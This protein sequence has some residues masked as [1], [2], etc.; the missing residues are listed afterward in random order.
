M[1][2][3]AIDPTAGTAD[4]PVVDDRQVRRQTWPRQEPCCPLPSSIGTRKPCTGATASPVRRGGCFPRSR[5]ALVRL[6]MRPLPDGCR[7]PSCLAHGNPTSN[8]RRSRSPM[9]CSARNSSAWRLCDAQLATITKSYCLEAVGGTSK[10]SALTQ[11]AGPRRTGK[12]GT[13]DTRDELMIRVGEALH[14]HRLPGYCEHQQRRIA[15]TRPARFENKLVAIHQ[16]AQVEHRDHGTERPDVLQQDDAFLSDRSR[17]QHDQIAQQVGRSVS[18]QG[19][20]FGAFPRSAVCTVPIQQWVVTTSFRLGKHAEDYALGQIAAAT[21]HST[22]GRPSK[23]RPSLGSACRQPTRSPPRHKKAIAAIQRTARSSNK[24]SIQALVMSG[25]TPVLQS[26]QSEVQ[27]PPQQ[28]AMILTPL[29]CSAIT[30][31]QMVPCDQVGEFGTARCFVEQLRHGASTAKPLR[32]RHAEAR[33]T[34]VH[35]FSR[36]VSASHIL[37]HP[38]TMPQA[39]A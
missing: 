26:P 32:Q 18:C 4:G 15:V 13:A 36:Q 29:R 30:A 34:S 9:S 22:H 23:S 35:D 39:S 17:L 27:Q 31:L 28:V 2:V 25:S 10:I 12:E 8:T 16:P 38:L 1:P 3:A 6:A 5:D 19:K 7:P 14:D 11:S 37:E 33:L 24:A 20:K 21:A